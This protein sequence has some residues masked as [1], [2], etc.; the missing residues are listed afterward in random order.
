[1]QLYLFKGKINNNVH[2]QSYL[3]RPWASC[4]FLGL[5]SWS[6]PRQTPRTQ[7]HCQ[8]AGRVCAPRRGQHREKFQMVSK[9]Q[10]NVYFY[11][12]W[13]TQRDCQLVEWIT[14]QS[15]QY[16][17]MYTEKIFCMVY[18]GWVLFKDIK[19]IRI[20]TSKVHI[21]DLNIYYFAF[22]IKKNN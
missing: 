5:Y 17:H 7:N 6:S 22:L 15:F 11:V 19:N 13:F 9:R 12:D 21:F 3:Q 8:G 1:M 14:V 16:K 4:T 18:L 2:V 10:F 20:F